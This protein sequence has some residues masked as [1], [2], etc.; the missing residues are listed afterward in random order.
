MM[1][2][3]ARTNKRLVSRE[4]AIVITMNVNGV[5]RG[6]AERYTDSELREV[7]RLIKMKPAF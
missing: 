7:L 5:S 1:N 3:D 2:N 6:M 4:Q